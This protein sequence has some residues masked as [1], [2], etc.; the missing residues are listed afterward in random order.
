MKKTKITNTVLSKSKPS[1]YVAVYVINK[2][3]L[4]FDLTNYK[5]CNHTV[6]CASWQFLW[7][8]L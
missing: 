6:T 8:I 5:Q 3:Y 4:S 7:S 2:L 1:S